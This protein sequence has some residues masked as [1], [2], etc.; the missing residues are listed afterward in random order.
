MAA[1]VKV[2]VLRNVMQCSVVEV[3]RCSSGACCFHH[4]GRVN[5]YH[6]AWHNIPEQLSSPSDVPDMVI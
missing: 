4:Q 3:Y 6:T 2:T 1:S 5:F